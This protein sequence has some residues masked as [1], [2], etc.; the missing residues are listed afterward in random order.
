MNELVVN[1]D[2]AL[3]DAVDRAG[4]HV[5]FIDYDKYH[6]DSRGRFCENGCEETSPNC[7][8]LLFYEWDTDDSA[9]ETDDRTGQTAESMG[10]F[11][12]S[13]VMNGTFEGAINE[14]VRQ[15]LAKNPSWGEGVA[16]AQ[17]APPSI[18]SVQATDD[19]IV[20][21][22]ST[23]LV[24][25]GYGGRVFRPRPNGHQLIA[26]LVPCNVQ[27][28]YAKLTSQNWPEEDVTT[29]TCQAEEDPSTTT[30]DGPAPAPSCDTNALSGLSFDVFS[31]PDSNV[32]RKI[33]DAVSEDQTK[34]LT[35]TT[36]ASGNEKSKKA[37]LLKRTPPPNPSA[38][39]SYSFNLDWTP[40]DGSSCGISCPDAFL[41]FSDSP[42]G[43]QGG[44]G[45]GMTS[46]ASID[47]GCGT[48]SYEITGEDVPEE[49]PEEPQSEPEAPPPE[50]ALSPQYCFPTGGE[51]N[52]ISPDSQAQFTGI[53]CAGTAL[54][55]ERIKKD[56]PSTFINF[57]TTTNGVEYK[58]TVV[59][60][61]NCE[62][63]VTEMN[64]YQPL[65]GNDAN[66]MSM[67]LNNYKDCK[68][69]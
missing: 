36:D 21:G 66:Y 25:Y 39:D 12:P 18:D 67:M 57:N 51:H 34:Q 56:D 37:R 52:D 2:K 10:T 32:Y 17:G 40:S 50:P 59:W 6:A 31:G 5:T 23:S 68:S 29:D 7:A 35:W 9:E 11:T 63:T 41:S 24:P 38:Y 47:V 33:Y 13:L 16:T 49:E 15:S 27:A 62:S 14:R 1:M 42:C 43:H 26:N 30:E 69:R 44:E 4:D 8:G 65:D 46:E 3:S 45:N 20:R 22:Y 55:S 28:N 19:Q 53:A 64:T 54:E 61:M 60:E 48:Y 58:Y